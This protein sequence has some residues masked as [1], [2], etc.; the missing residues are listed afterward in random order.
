M[1]NS[2]DYGEYEAKARRKPVGP[3]YSLLR[4]IYRFAN[5]EVLHGTIL[6]PYGKIRHK[7]VLTSANRS[8]SHTYTVFYRVPAQLDTLAGAVMDFIYRE[9]APGERLTINLFA[10]STG[11]EAFT[12]ASVLRRS[13][14]QLDFKI[15]ASD[16]HQE[17]VD[18]ATAGRY[19]RAE[20]LHND[21][22]TDEFIATT[23]ERQGEDFVVRPEVK[24]RVAFTQANLLDPE[25]GSRFQSADIVV[26]QNV[27]FHLS[28]DLAASAFRNITQFLKPKSVLLIDGMDLDLKMA[29]TREANLQPLDEA[30]REI[31]QQARKHIGAAWWRY[32]YGAEPYSMFRRDRLRRYSTIFLR[33]ATQNEQRPV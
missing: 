29:L 10:C 4:D 2:V 21:E 9:R 26:A 3:L 30:H 14:P 25:L 28:P 19:T 12:V 24:A 17:M 31:Y 23:F 20:V 11:A 33:G 22:I 7:A 15:F 1:T 13:F 16:L 5:I 27:L 18:K 8:Q 32:Y 6:Y